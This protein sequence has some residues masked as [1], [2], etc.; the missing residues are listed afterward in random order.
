MFFMAANYGALATIQPKLN[1]KFKGYKM[2]S[3]TAAQL[4]Q[5]SF[6]HARV[7]AIYNQAAAYTGD[8]LVTIA[9]DCTI[10]FELDELT[11]DME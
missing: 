11:L 6:Q 1:N 2:N 4:S 10:Y 5:D 7:D 3:P 8:L 9:D